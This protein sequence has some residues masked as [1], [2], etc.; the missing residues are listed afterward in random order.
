M[1]GQA[2]RVGVSLEALVTGEPLLVRVFEVLASQV[3]VQVTLSSEPPLADSALVVAWEVT[4]SVVP[5]PRRRAEPL[6]TVL[7]IALEVLLPF[8]GPNVIAQGLLGREVTVAN[9]TIESLHFSCF[10]FGL[11]KCLINPCFNFI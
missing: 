10:A 9:P 1:P 5:H 6:A 4:P 3:A 2:V 7:Y 11:F 8:V